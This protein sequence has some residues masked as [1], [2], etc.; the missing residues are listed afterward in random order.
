MSDEPITLA[1][2]AFVIGFLLF[3]WWLIRLTS[4]PKSG[5]ARHCDDC[6]HDGETLLTCPGNAA[7]EIILWCLML[8]PGLIYSIWRRRSVK[9]RCGACGSTA[10]SPL[11]VTQNTR[12]NSDLSE[13]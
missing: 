12:E 11:S 13:K 9:M 6:Q 1:E 10:L 8:V 3:F 5:P 4:K 2:T 7:V